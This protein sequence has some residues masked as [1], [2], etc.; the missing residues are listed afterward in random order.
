MHNIHRKAKVL[1][2]EL[3]RFELTDFV[4][5]EYGNYKRDS[6]FQTRVR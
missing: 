4:T 5:N 1:A 6:K 2:E 3:G